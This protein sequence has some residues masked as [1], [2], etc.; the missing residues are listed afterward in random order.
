MSLRCV[1]ERSDRIRSLFSVSGVTHEH[2][3]N[4]RQQKKNKA[5]TGRT[6]NSTSFAARKVNSSINTSKTAM[7]QT[8]Q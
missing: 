5:E 6:Q 1:G 8:E 4:L 2:Y 3:T 7:Q